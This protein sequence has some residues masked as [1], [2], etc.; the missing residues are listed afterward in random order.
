M[1]E[2]VNAGTTTPAAFALDGR[3]VA[4]AYE[5]RLFRGGTDGSNPQAWYLRSAKPPQPAPPGPGPT[6]SPPE[7]PA[8]PQ[9]QYRPE[10][11]AYLANQRLVGQMFVHS[12]HDRLG[13]PQYAEGMAARSGP[14]SAPGSIR[15]GWL[16]A[17]G[18][19]EGSH[20]RDGNFKVGT[21]AFLLQGRRRAGAL[22]RGHRLRSLA[23]GRNGQLR[24]RRQ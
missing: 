4:G 23:R 1:V 8:P 19:W 24:Q 9:P 15:S 10:V 20:S 12:L 11:A 3:A 2:T 7:P 13:E 5:Y 6:P 14:G 22:A 16:R 18:N 21:G 17:L